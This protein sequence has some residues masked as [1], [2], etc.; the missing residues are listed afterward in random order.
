[1]KSK[2]PHVTNDVWGTVMITASLV[3]LKL[4][5][6]PSATVRESRLPSVWMTVGGGAPAGRNIA[7]GW[8]PRRPHP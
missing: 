8:K 3:G 5:H 1:M 7:M 2:S 6:D 4:C